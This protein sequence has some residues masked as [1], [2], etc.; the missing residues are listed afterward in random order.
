LCLCQKKKKKKKEDKSNNS[1]NKS[2][3]GAI[4]DRNYVVL[5]ILEQKLFKA[6]MKI[7]YLEKEISSRNSI[8]LEYPFSALLFK[9][10]EET[11]PEI[12]HFLLLA[13]SKSYLRSKYQL[14]ESKHLENLI[15][16]ENKKRGYIEKQYNSFLDT[17]NK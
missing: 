2:L 9:G 6:K 1:S 3:R 7:E 4:L 17:P 14:T 11:Y 13:G 8:L 10:I 5:S 16:S 15:D 12:Y